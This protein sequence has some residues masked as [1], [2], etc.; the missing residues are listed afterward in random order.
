MN[1][2]HEPDLFSDA[3]DQPG[4]LGC[5]IEIAATIAQ[6]IES[7]RL[8]RGLSRESIV[9]QMSFHLGE[10]LSEATLN[11]YTSQAQE[12]REI[13]LRR[14]M[15]FD[16]AIGSDVL[17]A[18]YARKR[19]GRQ[20]V[21]TEDGALLEWARLHQEEKALATRKRALEAMLT[22]TWSKK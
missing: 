3:P 12:G 18:L 16:A 13:S 9:Q 19:G 6:E 14:A 2:C 8:K 22:S 11:S 5:A 21:T 1:H 17:L 4:G 10:R 15:A 7:A 20:V